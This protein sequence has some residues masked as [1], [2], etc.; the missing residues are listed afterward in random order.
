MSSQPT[1]NGLNGNHYKEINHHYAEECSQ[2][3]IGT[4]LFTSE[5]VGEGHPGNIFDQVTTRAWLNEW[6]QM[7]F[8]RDTP[9][10]SHMKTR[11]SCLMD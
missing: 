8:S 7:L 6:A 1:V 5:S 10:V 2:D 11:N 3:D 9:G 4:F